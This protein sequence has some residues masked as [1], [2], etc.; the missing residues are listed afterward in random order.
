MDVGV[1][2]DAA[3][4]LVPPD[5]DADPKRIRRWRGAMAL[6]LIVSIGGNLFHI[7]WAC[8]F[9]TWAGFSGFAEA[10]EVAS[11]QNQ[12]RGIE[13]G[14]TRTEIWSTRIAQCQVLKKGESAAYLQVLTQQLNDALDRYARLNDGH[15]FRLPPCSE[16]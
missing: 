1:I 7:A 13:R 9:L 2:L 8:G 3:A 12:L 6:A 5:I 14:Q 15:S 11:I 4:Y 10:K 16:L